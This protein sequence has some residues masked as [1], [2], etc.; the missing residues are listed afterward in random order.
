[1]L[2]YPIGVTKACAF[3]CSI[4]SRQ[5][6]RFTDHPCP[7]I[8]HLLLDVPSFQPDGLLR[9]GIAL[10]PVLSMI[11][12]NVHIIGGNLDLPV[13]AAYHKTDFLKDPF[14]LAQNADITADCALR[15][16][17]EKLD[18]TFAD[19]PALVIGWGRIG[20]C[21]VR[22]LQALGCSVQAAARKDSDRAMI[23]T[24]GCDSL[25]IEELPRKIQDFHLI[26]N[27]VPAP[28]P[29]MAI[30]ES[31]LAYE[32]ASVPGL[33][34][35]HAISARGLPGKMAPY[36]SG[37]LIAETISRLNKEEML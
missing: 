26:F 37:K 25:S 8:T 12:Q 18:R 29:D 7:E 1:M 24:L 30:P 5:G 20:K 16:A 15:L 35:L 21:L 22:K 4:L 36:S 23:R 31:A 17:S 33:S 11:P 6:F 27:T 13:I 28:L 3:A 34:E 14:Y 10:D 2:I 19:A 9:G 32:L